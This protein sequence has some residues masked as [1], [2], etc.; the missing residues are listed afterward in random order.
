MQQKVYDIT[1]ELTREL[2]SWQG[3][4]EFDFCL[5][6]KR[7]EGASVNVGRLTMSTHQGTHADAP[8]H[9]LD[10]GKTIDRLDLDPFL[11]RALLF[12]VSYVNHRVASTDSAVIRVDDLRRIESILAPRLLLRTGAWID[13]TSFPESVLTLAADVPAYLAAHGV[14]LVGFDVPSVDQLDSK[15]L[16]IHHALASHGIHILESLQ[17]TGVPEGEYELIALPLKIVGGDAAPVRAVL[18]TI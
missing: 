2:A 1:L 3:D 6:W 10:N 14:V 13:Y 18:R 15:Q 8:S 16:P 4:S 17:L 7:S 11:G 9:F 5:T 12:D